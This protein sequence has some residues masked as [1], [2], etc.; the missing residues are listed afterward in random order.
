MAIEDA[1]VLAR[2]LRR[3]GVMADNL[4]AF[5]AERYPRT[6]AITTASWRVG[7]IGQWGGRLSC[8]LRD[9][10]F[11]LLVPTVGLRG[12]LSYATFDVGS[13]PAAAPPGAS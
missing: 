13:L 12:L 11:G 4:S 1:A 5:V 3:E 6:S 10:L 9:E 7:R 2:Q 8:W